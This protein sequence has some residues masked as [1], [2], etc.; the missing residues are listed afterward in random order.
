MTVN[1]DIET[2]V[3]QN[4]LVVPAAAV[5][6]AAGGASTVQV[7]QPAVPEAEITAAG[8][9]GIISATPPVVVPVTIGLSDDTSIQ[10]LSGL[11]SGEQIVVST[12]TGGATTVSAAASATSRTGGGGF[13]GGGGGATIRGL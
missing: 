6:T 1:A 5:K 12:R 7:F 10:I 9:A 13:G 2:G 8:S 11:T 4:T 3:A